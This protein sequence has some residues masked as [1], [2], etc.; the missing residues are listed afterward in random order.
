MIQCRLRCRDETR[1][2]YRIE[3]KIEFTDC[4]SPVWQWIMFIAYQML[5]FNVLSLDVE[6]VTFLKEVQIAPEAM[7]DSFNYSTDYL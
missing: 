7:S 5:M 4:N 1:L 2:I 6:T 3:K